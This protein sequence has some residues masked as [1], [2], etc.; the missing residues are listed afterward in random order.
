MFNNLNFFPSVELKNLPEE[1]HNSTIALANK[2]YFTDNS[3]RSKEKHT[4]DWLQATKFDYNYSALY[5]G[6]INTT[7]DLAWDFVI[8]Y[9]NS[10]L[11]IESKHQPNPIKFSFT[12]PK[13]YEVACSHWRNYDIF[14]SW[15]YLPESNLAKVNFIASPKLF[16][17]EYDCL[18]KYNGVNEKSG[19]HFYVNKISENLLKRF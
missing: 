5:S 14:L 11:K 12:R 10:F 2:K 19:S 4:F 7:A 3:G 1:L 16:S 8:P 9:K 15:T 13:R 18:W 6:H 17:M